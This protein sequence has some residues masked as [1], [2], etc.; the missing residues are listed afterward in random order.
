MSTLSTWAYRMTGQCPV[1]GRP[2]AC[3][4]RGA[5]Q[6]IAGII[7]SCPNHPDRAHADAMSSEDHINDAGLCAICGSAWPCSRADLDGRDFASLCTRLHELAGSAT[8]D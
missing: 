5:D 4:L 6:R 3:T 1:D 8:L 2:M 7:R